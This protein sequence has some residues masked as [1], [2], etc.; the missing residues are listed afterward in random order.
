MSFDVAGEA[1]DR[2]VG[3]YSRPLAPGFLAFAAVSGGPVLDV[4]AGPGALTSVLVERFGSSS[5]AAVEPSEPFA[6]AC[7]ARLPGVDVR[8]AV[9]E[10]LGA[11]RGPFTLR[12]RALAAR[13]VR[14]LADAS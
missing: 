12:A 1:Y 11:P 14:P 8:E 6:A 7:R 4:G 5:V 3:R 2:L 9:R 13:G 10:I